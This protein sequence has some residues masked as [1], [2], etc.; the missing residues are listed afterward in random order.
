MKAQKKYYLTDAAVERI[1]LASARTGLRESAIVEW[2]ITAELLRR[3]GVRI[4][5]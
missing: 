2:A 4:A 1:K 5:R 3:V